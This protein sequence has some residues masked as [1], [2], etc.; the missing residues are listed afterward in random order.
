[1]YETLH[2]VALRTIRYSDSRSILS[3]WTAERGFMS[4]AL[5]AGKSREATRRRAL[6]MPLSAFE[7]V[8]DIRPGRDIS[9]IRDIKPMDVGMAMISDPAKLAMALFLAE[10][11]ERLLRYSQRDDALSLTIFDTLDALNHAGPRGVANFALWT[12]YRLTIPLGIAPDM[13]AWSRGALF[14]PDSGRWTQT[15]LTGSGYD[16]ARE[17]TAARLLSRMTRD[18]IERLRLTRD[19]RRQMLDGLLRYYEIHFVRLTPLHSLDVVR[20]LF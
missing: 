8:C 10:V 15:R 2:C 19:D 11:F 17:S 7:G 13:S 5:P 20:E 4:F 18:N 1:M 3:A 16:S 14:D 12:L 9:F 6:T